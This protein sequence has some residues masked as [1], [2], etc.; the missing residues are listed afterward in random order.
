M[1]S[2]ELS[3]NGLRASIE[4]LPLSSTRESRQEGFSWKLPA[5]GGAQQLRSITRPDG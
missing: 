4:D 1:G 2:Q 3:A 5:V